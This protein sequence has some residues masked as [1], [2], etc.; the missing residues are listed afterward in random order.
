MNR[1]FLS[2]L[3]IIS[4]L[5]FILPSHVA[6]FQSQASAAE[7]RYSFG[8]V[9]QFEQRK[10]FDIWSP[11]IDDLKKRTGLDI[12]LVTT[13]TIA[14]FESKFSSGEFDFT[15][16]NPYHSALACEAQG[17]VPLVADKTPLRGIV[18][19]RNDS[20]VREISDLN[21]KVVA[22][23]SPNAIG[24]CLLVK[25][26][27]E[28]LFHVIVKPLYVETHSSVYLHVVKEL[29]DAGGG[30]E[31]TLQEQAPDIRAALRVLYTT[32]AFPSHPVMA[33]PRVPKTAQEKVRRA[34]LDMA[35]TSAGKELLLKAPIKQLVSVSAVDYTPMLKWGLDKYWA[36]VGRK[37]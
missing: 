23:P 35:E 3:T 19:V 1:N 6:P 34:F 31:K 26:D 11:I 32:R 9:P 13:L 17:Y 15:Y 5:L 2:V 30:V 27:L 21:G 18:V 24:A 4:L 16:T 12:E 8:V 25:A 28:Q 14:D 10:L 20:T 7:R 33:H 37:D 36:P 22:F 29:A